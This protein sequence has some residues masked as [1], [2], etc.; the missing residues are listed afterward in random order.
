MILVSLEKFHFILTKIKE[1]EYSKK[2]V[3][4]I[5]KKVTSEDT[6]KI[7]KIH[8]KKRHHFQEIHRLDYH[9]WK[10]LNK[11]Y[12]KGWKRKFKFNFMLENPLLSSKTSTFRSNHS[13]GNTR[14]QIFFCMSSQQQINNET[15]LPCHTHTL[16]SSFF[17][18]RSSSSSH[19]FLCGTFYISTTFNVIQ[20]HFTIH[21]Q[22]NFLS[23]FLLFAHLLFFS[24][25]FAHFFANWKLLWFQTFSKINDFY[26]IFRILST[27]VKL[28]I[29][30]NEISRFFPMRM[31]RWLL[32]AWK[33]QKSSFN[34]RE[35]DK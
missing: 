6:F 27:L 18:R 34:H 32:K 26:R 28:I 7:L 1:Q 13:D 10:K 23:P 22:W 25:S 15:T 21:S 5:N 24:H 19:F 16:H 33:R 14:V 17:S 4:G 8:Q 2:K 12:P 20:G 3:E 30:F 31:I 9:I 11:M 35:E 29:Y